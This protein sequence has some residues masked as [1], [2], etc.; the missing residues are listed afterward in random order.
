M[1]NSIVLTRIKLI[2]CLSIV[3]SFHAVAQLQWHPIT[4]IPANTDAQRFDDVFFL[5]ANLGWALGGGHAVVYKTIDGGTTWTPQL[6]ESALGSNYYFRNVEFLTP[7]IGFVGTLI[8]NKFF[9]T[10]DGGTTWSLVTNIPTAPKAI[11]GLDAVGT[12]TV[13]GCGAYFGPA[14]IIKSTDSGATWQYT[15]MAAYATGLVEVVFLDENVGYAAGKNST[16]AIILK[17]LNGGTTWTQIYN[18]GIAGEYVWKMQIL[19]GNSN[20]LFGAVESIA[21]NPGKLIKSTDGG[22]I[23]VSKN[24]PETDI[25]AVGFVTENHGWMGGHNTG[26]YET[27]DG[28]DTWTNLNVGSNL[29]RIFIVNDNLAYASGTT[30]YK[31]NDVNLDTG[32]FQE[33]G[34]VP[35][36]AKVQPN[37][38][39]DKLNISIDFTDVDNLVIELYNS[40]GKRIKELKVD[41]IDRKGR[42]TYS[43]NFPYPSGIYFVNLHTNTGRQSVKV[44]K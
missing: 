15:N 35:L 18:S 7:E 30:I 32:D 26:F 36:I 42:K 39:T 5:D 17:T 2:V 34:R 22:T 9:K 1:K 19:Q 10:T 28:G 33:T 44:I 8:N 25:Q 38:I 16:G 4:S 21:P 37:P 11:C 43:F 40:L 41:T 20:V 27:L 12:S 24:A 6:S 14:F 31:Y 3:F 29:N 23:W 13:Y